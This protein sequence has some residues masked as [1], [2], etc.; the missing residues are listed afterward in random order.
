MTLL[1]Y[2]VGKESASVHCQASMDTV[3]MICLIWLG[4]PFQSGYPWHDITRVTPAEINLNLDFMED[5]KPGNHRMRKGEED[6]KRIRCVSKAWLTTWSEK[7]DWTVTDWLVPT[8]SS[9]TIC[10]LR[11]RWKRVLEC[12]SSVSEIWKIWCVSL[13]K[14]VSKG[15]AATKGQ[16]SV[17]ILW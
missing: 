17:I 11:R 13:L 10:W 2:V 9:Q 14:D 3:L 6:D 15:Q 1:Y 8:F 16:Y 5:Q 7:Q 4:F 12:Q